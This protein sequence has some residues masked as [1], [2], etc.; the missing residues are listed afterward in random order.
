MGL[1]ADVYHIAG[2]VEAMQTQLLQIETILLE[3]LGY[4][5][6]QP[7]VTLFQ[8]KPWLSTLKKK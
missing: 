4:T 3:F 1:W 2:T 8:V 7:Q 5:T 6:T